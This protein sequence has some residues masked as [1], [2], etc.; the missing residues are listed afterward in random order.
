MTH[1]Q[2]LESLKRKAPE[3]FR[4]IASKRLTRSYATLKDLRVSYKMAQDRDDQ[5]EMIRIVQMAEDIQKDIN[6]YLA[7]EGQMTTLA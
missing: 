4:E 2:L 7:V 5:A 3:L 1:I 6:R